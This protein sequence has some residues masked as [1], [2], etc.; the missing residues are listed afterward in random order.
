MTEDRVLRL[1]PLL[2]EGVSEIYFHPAIERTPGPCRGHAR[3]PTHRRAGGAAEPA[4]SA[5]ASPTSA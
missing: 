4:G 5:R 3:L 2:P 1:L